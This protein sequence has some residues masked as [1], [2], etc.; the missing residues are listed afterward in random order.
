VKQLERLR[1]GQLGH[2]PPAR[3]AALESAC[4]AAAWLVVA[5]AHLA[6]LDPANRTARSSLTW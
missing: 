6:D 4:A 5:D 1:S 3:I 2:V